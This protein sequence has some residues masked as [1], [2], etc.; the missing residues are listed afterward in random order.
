MSSLN[1]KAEAV[2]YP[3]TAISSGKYHTVALKDDGTVWCWG[4]NFYGQ[5]GDGTTTNK[6]TP[7]QVS[8]LPKI[9]AISAGENYTAALDSNG[10]VWCWGYNNQGQLGDGTTANKTV[11]VKV[12]G[13]SNIIAIAAG[14]YHTVAL[15]SSGEVWCWGGDGYG[16]LGD[17]ST[18]N[19]T[20]PVKISGLPSITA[21]AAGGSHTVALDSSG[22][23]WCWGANF[24][25][26]VGNNSD[27]DQTTPV[28]LSNLTNITAIAAGC[29]HTV[30]LD[31]TGEVWCWGYNG[32]GQ[33]GDGST[34]TSPIP[35]KLSGLTNVTVI[36]TRMQHTAVLKDDGTVWCWGANYYGQLGDGSTKNN[37]LTPVQVVGLTDVKAIATGDLYTIGLK[38]NGTV[39]GWGDNYYGELGNGTNTNTV[40]PKLIANVAAAI[41]TDTATSDKNDLTIGYASGDNESSITQNLTLAA[42]GTKG[43]NITWKSNNDSVI[44]DDGIVIRPNFIEANATVILMATIQSGG[45]SCTKDFT[46]TV[47]KSNIPPAPTG[48]MGVGT[49][50]IGQSDGKITGTTTAMEYKLETA[51]ESE[52][53]TCGDT[54]TTGLAAGK[55]DVRIKQAGSNMA[56]AAV[57]VTVSA[58]NVPAAPTGLMGV[59]TSIIGQSDGKI[60]GTTTVMEYKLETALESE[61]KTCGDTETT[62][63][64]AGR[65]DVRIKQAGSNMASEA[66]KVTVLES[67]I[68]AAPTGLAGIETSIIGKSDGKITGTTTSME[69]KLETALESEYKTCGD[70][71]TAGLAAG[72]YDVRIKQAGSNMASA[73]AKVTVL[74]SNIPPAPTGLAGVG[75]SIIGESDGKIT[76]TTTSMEYK[77]ETAL[78][79][80]YKTCG[81][82]ETAGLSAGKYDVRIKQAGVNM[83]SEAVK[84]T[85]PASNVPAAPA[86]LTAIAGDAQVALSWNVVQ[87]ADIYNVYERT[88]SE[89]YSSTPIA[90]ITN[91]TNITITNLNNGT[92]Y[93][94]VVKAKNNTSS[95]SANSAEVSAIPKDT[96]KPVITLLGASEVTL[97]Y[98]ASY[99]DEGV[100]A[101]DGG[102]GDITVSTVVT[103]TNSLGI[104]VS[105]INTTQPGSYTIHYNVS[106]AA[107]NAANEVIRTVVV[108]A[109]YPPSNSEPQPTSETREVSLVIKNGG[110][111]VDVAK[112]MVTRTTYPNGLKED[113]LQVDEGTAEK[114]VKEAKKANTTSAAILLTGIQG[115]STDN[116]KVDLP[117]A[118]AAQ[119]VG[120]NICL[121]LQTE[122]ATFELLSKTLAEQKNKD[123]QIKISEEKNSIKIADTNKLILQLVAD[124]KI[125]T[126]PLNIE[127]SFTGRVKITIPIDSSKLPASKEELDKF[128]SSLAVMVHHSDGEDVVDKGTIVYDEEGNVIGISIWVDKF[129]SFTLVETP[130]DYFQG[131]TTVMKD[132]AA[133]DKEWQIK[134][135]KAADAATVNKDNVYVVDSKGNKVDIKVS[136]GLDNILKVTP[137]NPY[138]SGEK[139][140]LYITKAVKAKDGTS[141]V[142]E[143]RYQFTI[144]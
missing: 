33:L 102:N 101:L 48:L 92:T 35:K 124:G 6:N 113:T 34:N 66:V 142:N 135:T 13:L 122:K 67:N 108:K 3:I 134:F 125:I 123:I 112:I 87:G 79:S 12:S 24:Y 78:E 70:V 25:K 62:G 58:S 93:Y 50:I 95:E 107:G 100:T 65:Y 64:A 115:T 44:T 42:T 15:S 143:L 99:T 105:A 77:L 23:V 80:E 132:K 110:K 27:Q 41:D 5:L 88:E 53:K 11:P 37:R 117:K 16:Q 61:Y 47:L 8:G 14:C 133:S 141:L 85:V 76:G 26:Q 32:S 1:A 51:L 98:G 144:K 83:A 137:I 96:V 7:V 39:W 128:L 56:S 97:S 90:S 63:L 120:D 82:V 45:Y 91:G 57:T 126:T 52:Y 118:S 2:P 21:I 40:T 74:E 127:T 9:T 121:T 73:A 54:E 31:S 18:A 114:I 109:Y 30:A 104:T 116:I 28:Q 59:G 81:D 139:Y 94:F 10:E 84:V 129:S 29:Y 131:K 60:T 136:Y 138:K 69:Y 106:D 20:T 36:A 22:K 38:E 75:T 119:L 49:S 72:R 17:G 19:K 86:N 103:I 111:E 130:K 55:Y 71:E 4:D 140:Y 89:S 43:S 46:V 68:P